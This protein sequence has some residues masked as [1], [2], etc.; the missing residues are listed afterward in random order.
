[1]A[2]NLTR[3]AGC[4]AST[5]H[6]RATAATIR[7]HLITVPARL[8]RSARRVTLHLP[9]DW[10]WAADWLQLFDTLHAPP[11]TG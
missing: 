8:A 3:A 9:T 10:L 11:Q 4:L 7:R 2:F 6:A 1:M 5:F